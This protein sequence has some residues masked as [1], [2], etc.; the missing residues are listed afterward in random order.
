M[1]AFT[2][3]KKNTVL[4]KNDENENKK[5]TVIVHERRAT[6]DIMEKPTNDVRIYCELLIKKIVKCVNIKLLGLLHIIY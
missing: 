4:L 2:N 3:K 5:T 1:V 6:T